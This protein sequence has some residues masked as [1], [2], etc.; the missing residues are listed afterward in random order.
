MKKN[1]TDITMVLDASGS[2]TELK[3]ATLEGINSFIRTQQELPGDCVLSLT[4]F[5]TEVT[6]IRVAVPLKSVEPFTDANYRTDGGTALLDAHPT[7][8]LAH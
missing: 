4:Q 3:S 5:N 6:P 1:L 8:E 7:S 2:M